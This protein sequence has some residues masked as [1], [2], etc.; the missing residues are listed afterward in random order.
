MT[1]INA[2]HPDYAKT[3]LQGFLNDLRAQSRQTKAGQAMAR[4]VEARRVVD[5]SHGTLAGISKAPRVSKPPKMIKRHVMTKAAQ[6]MTMD[7]VRMEIALML[8]RRK[9]K[10]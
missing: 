5:P 4:Y 8:A 1:V 9:D 3:Y 10:K 7:E 6:S 2:F